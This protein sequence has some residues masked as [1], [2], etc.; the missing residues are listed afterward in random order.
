[1]ALSTRGTAQRI[2]TDFA[3]G[4]EPPVDMVAS[5][6]A[7]LAVVVVLG[8]VLAG[9]LAYAL[10]RIVT[11]RRPLMLCM[12]V[13]AGLCGFTEPVWDTLSNIWFPQIGQWTGFSAFGRAIPVW[14]FGAYALYWGVLPYVFLRLVGTAPPR[15]KLAMGLALLVLA[16]AAMEI[17]LL[18]ADLHDYYGPHGLTVAGLPLHWMLINGTAAFLVG[19]TALRL[20]ARLPGW[21]RLGVL[22]V[23]PLVQPAVSMALGWPFFVTVHSGATTAAVWV[24]STAVVGLSLLVLFLVAPMALPASTGSDRVPSERSNESTHP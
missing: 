22:L 4:P 14:I 2:T 3:S 9:A 11:V 6:N 19:V 20:D 1:M 15:R 21:R 8:V 12:V 13:G 24:A 17:P 10:W 5:T 7:Q 18:I 16:N 23:P